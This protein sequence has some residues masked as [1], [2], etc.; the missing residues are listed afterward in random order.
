MVFEFL[1]FYISLD[2]FNLAILMNVDRSS[3][4]EHLL[5]DDLAV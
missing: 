3:Y 5:T 1:Q 4:S 2:D